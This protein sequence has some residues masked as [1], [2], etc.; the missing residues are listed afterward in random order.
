MHNLDLLVL[1]YRTCKLWRTSWI[2]ISVYINNQ[3]SLFSK[4]FD[5]FQSCSLWIFFFK[6]CWHDLKS[7][8]KGSLFSRS[9]GRN[10]FFLFL[11][12]IFI[13]YVESK[14]FEFGF[15]IFPEFTLTFYLGRKYFLVLPFI[16]IEATF[17]SSA[18]KVTGALMIY[19][20]ILD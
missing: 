18:D 2:P 9:L 10:F 12:F 8:L 7:I 17:G 11:Y 3:F 19:L 5:N 14:I 13:S 1:H 4:S 20:I 16:P 15:S 6:L